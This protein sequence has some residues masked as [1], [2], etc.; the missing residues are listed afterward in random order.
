VRFLAA[1]LFLSVASA[2]Q[3]Q[4]LAR[5]HLIATGGTIA[6][7]P[8]SRLTHQELVRSVPGLAKVA[9]VDSEQFSNVTSDALTP[10]EWLQLAR[11]IN[12]V[13]QRDREI[14]GIVIT[15]GTDTLE[16]TAYFLNLT[17]TDERPVVIVG[18]MRSPAAV[19]Y[20][21]IANLSDGVRVAV[22]PASRNRGVLVVMNGQIHPARDVTKADAQ[23]LD[24]FQTRGS[25]PLGIV[26]TD[27][28]LFYRAPEKR[29]TSR[30]E[31][32]IEGVAALPRVDVIL[33]YQ[34]APADLI[35]AAAD[36]GAR[37]IVMAG[38]GAGSISE[39]QLDGVAYAAQKG[40]F[41]VLT[42]RTGGGRVASGK[43]DVA[44]ALAPPLRPF[45]IAGEDLAPVKARVLLMLALASTS[46]P[47][48]IQRAFLNY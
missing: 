28:V 13:F 29:H 40:I 21:G 15:S 25:G 27:R 48:D 23:R 5:V 38:A 14:A 31:W 17:V 18:S 16:E 34:G 10:A 6:N 42:T 24:A 9:R 37:G 45:V 33:V 46:V 43:N 47:A 19:G 44:A 26:D 2:A 11:R 1:L 12:E 39:Q 4:E 35:R 3:A 41:V 8:E 20:D 32:H 30:A 7:R 36:F 22:L